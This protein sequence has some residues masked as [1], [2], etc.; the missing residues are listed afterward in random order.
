MEAELAKGV[1]GFV[2]L[3][4]IPSQLTSTSNMPPA[5]VRVPLP[6]NLPVHADDGSVSPLPEYIPFG[7][8]QSSSQNTDKRVGLPTIGNMLITS[9]L[10]SNE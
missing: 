3:Y 1:P 5:P 2:P 8:V 4:P 7:S 6:L 9:C 10:L